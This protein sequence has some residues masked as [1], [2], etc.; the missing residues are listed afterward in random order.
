MGCQLR[1]AS[2]TVRRLRL[3]SGSPPVLGWAKVAAYPV[4]ICG[5]DWLKGVD[6][7]DITCH[8]APPATKIKEWK[9]SNAREDIFRE[10]G[11]RIKAL[12][13][14]KRMTLDALSLQIGSSKSALSR[15]ETAERQPTLPQLFDLA[16]ALGVDA[17]G[18]IDKPRPTM[19]GPRKVAS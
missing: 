4:P 18:L 12:R 17:A 1:E 3:H 10:L 11:I 8:C 14:A 16:D 2:S 9:L 7:A 6:G 5:K 19:R 13:E 15:I